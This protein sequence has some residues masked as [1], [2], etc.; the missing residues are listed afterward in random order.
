[1]KY[2]FNLFY[3]YKDFDSLVAAFRS[4]I[5]NLPFYGFAV[6]CI[7]HP[8]VRKLIDD[9][10]ERKV[11]TYGIDSGDANITA[12]N[13]SSDAYSSTFDV[14]INLPNMKCNAVIEG[15]TIPTPGRHNVLNSLAAVAIGA[16]LN[17]GIKTLKDGFKNF[18]GVKRRFTRVGEYKDAL[19]IDDYAHHPVEV[20]ATLAT[21]RHVANARNGRVVAIFQPHRY[22]RLKS[23]FADFVGCFKDADLLYITDVYSAGETAIEGFSGSSLVEET[24]KHKNTTEYIASHEQI[25]NIV[26]KVIKPQDL[27]VMMG[28]GSISIWAN[29]LQEQ[30]ELL[31]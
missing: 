12:Y 9:I 4:F 15:I 30:L 3:Y 31:S 1:M 13:I 26:K 21:A 5:T 25:P 22:S 29:K 7:D 11:I 8:V 14:K 10:H 18:K 27:V 28:A 24:K 16:E 20:Q 6:V 2:I 23:L 17:F 19:I